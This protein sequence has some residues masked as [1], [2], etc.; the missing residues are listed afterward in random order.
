MIRTETRDVYVFTHK[1]TDAKFADRHKAIAHAAWYE[2]LLR[3]EQVQV[4]IAED[5]TVYYPTD[6]D[7]EE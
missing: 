4:E 1:G 6:F 7:P 3:T 5:G 2:K